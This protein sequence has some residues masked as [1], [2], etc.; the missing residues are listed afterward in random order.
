MTVKLQVLTEHHLEFLSLK[1]GYTISIHHECEIVKSIPKITH[2][3]DEACRVM[4]IG[5]PGD[6]L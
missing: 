1:E 4:T 6:G 5:D 2:L 3:H